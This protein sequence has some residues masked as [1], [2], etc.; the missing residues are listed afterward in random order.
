MA[1]D[2]IVKRPL[3][4]FRGVVAI[5]VVLEHHLPVPGELAGDLLRQFRRGE[6]ELSR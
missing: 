4:Q 3:M 5:I 2:E 6:P 1:G